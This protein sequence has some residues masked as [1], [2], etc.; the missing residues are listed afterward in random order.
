MLVGGQECPF[1]DTSYKLFDHA[2][3]PRPALTRLASLWWTYSWHLFFILSIYETLV[4]RWMTCRFVNVSC[5]LPILC[6]FA[7]VRNICRFF[8][9]FVIVCDSRFSDYFVAANSA[10]WCPLHVSHVSVV[11]RGGQFC[12]RSLS[13]P[14]L[15]WEFT[16]PF[17]WGGGFPHW[18]QKLFK[19]VTWRYLM[20]PDLFWTPHPQRNLFV[21]LRLIS[22][23]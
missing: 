8:K 22:F 19:S 23:I 12:S 6:T 17:T 5:W 9:S 15:D 7:K 1:K 20:W 18:P 2:R 11:T 13:S 10:G 21:F 16:S 3:M 14:F 4:Q